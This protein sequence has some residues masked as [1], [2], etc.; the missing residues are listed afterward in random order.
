MVDQTTNIINH[1]PQLWETSLH[2]ETPGEGK[3]SVC[4]TV[5]MFVCFKSQD[6]EFAFF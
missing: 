6:Q 2:K 1:S 4:H 5:R 3:N